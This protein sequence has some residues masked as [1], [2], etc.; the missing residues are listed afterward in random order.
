ML[1]PS[2]L[3]LEVELRTLVQVIYWDLK[4]NLLSENFMKEWGEQDRAGKKRDKDMVAQV[5]LSLISQGAHNRKSTRGSFLLEAAEQA[6]LPPYQSVSAAGHPRVGCQ[7]PR[8]FQVTQCLLAWKCSPEKA[9]AGTISS[10]THIS[11]WRMGT[12]AKGTWSG[13]KAI[14]SNQL[15]YNYDV[16]Y[17]KWNSV[18]SRVTF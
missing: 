10:Q 2:S 12:L 7:S 8:P 4:K 18:Y 6:F 1:R 3:E 17:W 14:Y 11:S 16:C 13:T 9:V 5:Y 15:R